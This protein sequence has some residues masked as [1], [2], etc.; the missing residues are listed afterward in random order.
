MGSIWQASPASTRDRAALEVGR[1]PV[2]DN[3]LVVTAPHAHQASKHTATHPQKSMLERSRMNH[4]RSLQLG[5]GLELAEHEGRH[6]LARNFEADN[7]VV[8]SASRN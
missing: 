4:Q 5:A 7:S 2:A 6:I 1:R 8:R 3:V